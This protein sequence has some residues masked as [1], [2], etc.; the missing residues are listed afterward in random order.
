MPFCTRAGRPFAVPP[1]VLVAAPFAAGWPAGFA[2]VADSSPVADW[3]FALAASD[4]LLASFALSTALVSP[5][6]PGAVAGAGA[7]GGTV[8]ALGRRNSIQA[9]RRATA[10]TMT[11]RMG[12]E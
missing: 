11:M 3:I 8:S 12:G 9:P 4:V 5:F 7:G 6:T 1:A 10:A 2:V